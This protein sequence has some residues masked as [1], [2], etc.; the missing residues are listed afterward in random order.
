MLLFKI[1]V[2]KN[3]NEIDYKITGPILKI[4]PSFSSNNSLYSFMSLSLI[5]VLHKQNNFYKLNKK[6]HIFFKKK[7]IPIQ[8]R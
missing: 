3:Y 2:K 5:Q 8:G 1:F 7:K 6:K 4:S